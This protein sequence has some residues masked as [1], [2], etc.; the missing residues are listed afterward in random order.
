[1]GEPMAAVTVLH[2]VVP[3]REVERRPVAPLETAD[4]AEPVLFQ[5]G[6]VRVTRER[7]VVG[8]RTWALRDV[9][10]VETVRRTPKVWPYL[11]V[12]GLGAVVG[13][14]LL[15]WLSVSVT[16]MRGA[17]EAGL[18]FTAL[19]FFAS[20]A[21]LLLVED[22]HYLVLGLPGGA[23]RVFGSRDAQL[24]A[25]LAGTVRAARPQP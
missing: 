20:M 1:M 17:Y 2:P 3:R 15:S 11:L 21:A 4:A 24:I 9:L 14:P 18:V 5:E 25:R 22:M 6:Q 16:A 23:R 10:Q 8:G 19:G 13:L 12:V 7:L